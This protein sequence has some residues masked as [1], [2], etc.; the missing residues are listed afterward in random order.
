MTPSTLGGMAIFAGAGAATGCGATGAAADL[1]AAL[2][3]A[4]GATGAGAALE[5][6]GGPGREVTASDVVERYP[7]I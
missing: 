3:A 6:R 5:A 2:G 1:D 7:I 4:A